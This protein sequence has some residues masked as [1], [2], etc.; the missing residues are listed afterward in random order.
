[1]ENK[2][3]INE[4]DLFEF[5]KLLHKTNLKITL[6]EGWKGNGI[7]DFESKFLCSFSCSSSSIAPPSFTMKYDVAISG[8]SNFF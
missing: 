6:K 5:Q 3:Y 4:R 8:K 2:H 1:L 7:Y